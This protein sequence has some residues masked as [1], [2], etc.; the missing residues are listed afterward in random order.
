MPNN[1]VTAKAR[2]IHGKMLTKDDYTVLI[3]KGTIPAAVAYLKTK[4]FYSAVFADT[5]EAA[6]HREQAEALINKNVYDNYLRVCRFAAGDKKGIMSFYTRQ[7]ECDQLIKAVIAISSGEQDGFIAAFPDHI[8]EDLSFDH[9]RLA[10]SKDLAAA[11]DV[12]KGTM[13]YRPLAPLMTEASPDIDKILTTINVCYIKWA[14]E[15]IDKSEKGRSREQLKDF[16]LRK[17]DADNLLMCYRLK[18]FGLDNSRINE[19][20]I[21]YHKRLRQVEIDAALKLPDPVPVLRE[22]FVTEKIALADRSDIPEVNVNISDHRYFRHRLASS[23][24]ETESLY[25]LMVLMTAE[26]TNLCR[27]TESLRYGLAPE[28]TEKLMI[29]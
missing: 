9:M 8:A 20:L 25:A 22:M 21:P 11:A 10:Q 23:T 29:F 3:H 27:I 2:A 24:N 28:E 16:F 14:F 7:L 18:V 6:V 17:A 4:P 15:M 12:L 5:D 19:L 1:A 13:Y 26:S